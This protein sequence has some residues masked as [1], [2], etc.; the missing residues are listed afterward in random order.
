M[1]RHSLLEGR[2]RLAAFLI[3]PQR[4]PPG[5]D[6]GMA[7]DAQ[8]GGH[9]E[10]SRREPIF[11]IIAAAEPVLERGKPLLHRLDC[12]RPTR[13]RPRLTGIGKRRAYLAPGSGVRP[14]SMRRTS[15]AMVRAR[16]FASHGISVSER[17][18]M[19][20]TMAPDSNNLS[21]SVSMA[22][23]WPNGC[24]ARYPGLARSAGPI[25]LS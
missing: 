17:S 10:I 12:H 16:P 13:R 24:S 3:R 20:S 1:V 19:W 8:H 25:S 11:E 2:P 14:N 23:T 21:S 18:A 5:H 9:Q 22:G 6:V 4:W 15:H 7:Q